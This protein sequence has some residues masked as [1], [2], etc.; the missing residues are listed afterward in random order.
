MLGKMS[1]KYTRKIQ[2]AFYTCSVRGTS[3]RSHPQ[4]PLALLEL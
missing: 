2:L 3:Q 4:A 1:F